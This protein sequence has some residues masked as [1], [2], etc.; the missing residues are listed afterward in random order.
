APLA[1]P[2]TPDTVRANQLAVLNRRLQ[3]WGYCNNPRDFFDTLTREYQAVSQD[4]KALE[5]WVAQRSDWIGEGDG[6]LDSIQEFI[7]GGF[8]D[9]SSLTL[10]GLEIHW[11]N[12]SSV[13][14]KVQYMMA[15]VEVR[16]D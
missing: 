5:A 15:A 16:L 10:D 4:Q 14:Y 13:V 8:L 9:S 1:I 7:C 11:K 2:L 12:I 6:I 3:V